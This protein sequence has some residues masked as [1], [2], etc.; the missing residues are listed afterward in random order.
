MR[1]VW[2]GD[3][4]DAVFFKIWKG[5]QKAEVQQIL[6]LFLFF[7]I[8]S[9][10]YFLLGALVCFLVVFLTVSILFRVYQWYFM[11]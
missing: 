3:D 4:Q 11:F 8:F 1:F 5:G 2:K 7:Y 9:F 10:I 6:V